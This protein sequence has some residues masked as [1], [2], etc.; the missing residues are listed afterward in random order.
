MLVAPL[1]QIPLI[2]AVA[3]G[4]ALPAL[5]IYFDLKR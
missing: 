2:I 4:L 5:S 3:A 1:I